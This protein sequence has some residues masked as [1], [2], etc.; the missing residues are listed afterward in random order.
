MSRSQKSEVGSQ[1]EGETT[2]R[3]RVDAP[4]ADGGNVTAPDAEPVAVT[5]GL[6]NPDYGDGLETRP[7]TVGT[8]HPTPESV[9]T[10]TAYQRLMATNKSRFAMY[11][12]SRQVGK[13]FGAGLAINDD[14]MGVEARG[15]RTLWTMISRSMDQ[16][17]ELTRKV[18]DI[19]RAVMAA[20]N[21]LRG[22]R[23]GESTDK[24]GETVFQLTYPNESR[25]IVVSGNP[26]AA[27]GYTGNVWWDE[28]ALTQRAH[29]L[30]GTA[31]PVVSRG[32]YRFI[33]T[34]TPRPGFW[35]TRWDEAQKPGS[36]WFTHT[37]T[38][39][40]AIAQ[41]CPMNAEEL[42]AGLRDEMRWRQEYLCE[43]VD[44]DVCWLAWEL[45]LSATDRRA[46]I[47]PSETTD[48]VYAGWDIARWN[49]KSTLW[50]IEKKGLLR[51]TCGVLRMRRMKF[52]QQYDLVTAACK[53]HAKFVRL[54]L[55]QTG[56]GEP[57][58]ETMRGRLGGKVEG[59]KF[60]GP[61]KEALAGDLRHALEERNFLLPDDDEVRAD[62]HSVRC[63][64]T[65]AGNK[66][67]EGEVEGSHADDFWAAGLANH[68]ATSKR[69][70]Y[71]GMA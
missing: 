61:V 22:I 43:D 18:R 25:V 45:L 11:R 60:S 8:A 29:D 70:S 30:F 15:Q 59:V 14:I 42:R 48:G 1:K 47:E 28:A 35:K 23:E 39:H 13:S 53:R 24:L 19:G 38:I 71:M 9:I 34:S 52:E 68:A 6:K 7:T 49:H 54:C 31:F 63:T 57:I 41:G 46:T 55:D 66:R 12:W 37:L 32:K 64:T 3:M 56:M 40:D 10:P 16:A 65:A 20:R 4:M 36:A 5:S 62:L 26:D 67:F 44:D 21:I 2:V 50:L 27:A 17:R 33:M 51:R 58:Y 69:G